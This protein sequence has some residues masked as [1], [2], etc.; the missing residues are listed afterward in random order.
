[1]KEDPK[2]IGFIS[3]RGTKK[4]LS[5]WSN[6]CCRLCKAW[7]ISYLKLT[8]HT[9]YT[10][11]YYVGELLLVSANGFSPEALPPEI[12]RGTQIDP[13]STMLKATGDTIAA[14]MINR[15]AEGK[16]VSESWPGHFKQ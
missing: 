1:M 5:T 9:S 14:M 11:D 4:H 12:T 8:Y 15:F 13:A 7:I 2:H 10:F 3:G 6:I 16:L